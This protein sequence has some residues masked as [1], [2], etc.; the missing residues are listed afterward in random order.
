MR[1]RLPQ[2][3]LSALHLAA[4]AGFVSTVDF[5]LDYGAS[6]ESVDRVSNA[7]NSLHWQREASRLLATFVAKLAC[8]GCRRRQGCAGSAAT[9]KAAALTIPRLQDGRTALLLAAEAG[10]TH[11]LHLLLNQG[12]KL[13]TRDPV[14]QAGGQVTGGGA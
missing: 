10:A 11:V 8:P 1:A 9:Q 4:R 2:S 12:A 13:E 14:S 7:R 3:E 5:L 6:L